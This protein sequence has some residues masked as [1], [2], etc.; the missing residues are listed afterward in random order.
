LALLLI[1]D[2][3]AVARPPQGAGA[4]HQG[5]LPGRGRH[6][7][8]DLLGRGLAHRHEGPALLLS[9]GEF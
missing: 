7:L 3:A 5:L 4:V 9:L 2:A 8:D 6:G 1:N